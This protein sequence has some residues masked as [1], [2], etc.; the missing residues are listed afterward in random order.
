MENEIQT[1]QFQNLHSDY[2][3]FIQARAFKGKMY[4]SNVKDFLIWMECHGI[5]S[6]TEI[7]TDDMMKYYGYLCERP[8]KRREGTLADN[9]IRANLLAI[10]LFINHLLDKGDLEINFYIP[11]HGN[12]GQQP[13]D[14]LTVDEVKILYQASANPLERVLLSLAYGCGLRRTEINKLN[15]TDIQILSGMLVVRSGKGDKRREVP[16]SNTVLDDVKK[17]ITEYRYQNTSSKQSTL[18][19]F[20]N[21]KGNRMSGDMLN[22]TLKKIIKCSGKQTIIDKEISLHSLRHS[23]AHHLMENNASLDFIRGFLG[24]TYINTTYIYAVKNKKRTAAIKRHQQLK[25]EPDYA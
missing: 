22:E 14:Y 1:P 8:N 7:R 11:R 21:K 17:Y 19:F 9:T 15:T 10:T 23:I 5:A 24:H 2:N 13:R 25:H 18:S 16:M 12:Q 4:Q 6:I 20:I 3:T